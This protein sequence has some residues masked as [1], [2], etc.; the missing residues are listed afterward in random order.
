MQLGMAI[1]RLSGTP[2]Q[3]MRPLVSRMD[4]WEVLEIAWVRSSPEGPDES[5]IN[6][7]VKL[8]GKKISLS[9]FPVV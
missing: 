6:L 8:S 1:F 3:C 4:A 9:M 2:H 5:S 7:V